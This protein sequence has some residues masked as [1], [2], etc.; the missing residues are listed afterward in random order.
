VLYSQK[1]FKIKNKI[2]TE[3]CKFSQIKKKSI[4]LIK[5]ENFYLFFSKEHF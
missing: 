1:H 3:T 5:L 2:P 4:E